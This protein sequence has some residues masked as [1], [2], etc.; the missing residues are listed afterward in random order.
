MKF[1]FN[2]K[3]WVLYT[4]LYLVSLIHAQAVILESPSYS[5]DGQFRA[6]FL[7]PSSSNMHYA[8]QATPLPYQ[9]PHWN[10]YDLQPRYHFG[11][12]LGLR[13][14]IHSCDTNV[15][16]NWIHF[17]SRTCG[18][19]KVPV[20][21]DMV[22]SFFA[23]GPDSSVFKKA[24]GSAVFSFDTANATFGQYIQFGERLQTNIFAGVSF[25]RIKECFG[26]TYASE[27][28]E[29]VRTIKNPITLTAGG[30]Q[31][32]CDFSYDITCGIYLSGHATASI[33]IGPATDCTSYSTTS[34]VLALND[35]PS[36]NNQSIAT[37]KR[38]LV[39]PGFEE[40]LGF[41]YSFDFCKNFTGRFEVGYEARVYLSALQAVNIG[42]EVTTPPVVPSTIGVYARTFQR[43]VSN[44]ALYG[45]YIAFDFTY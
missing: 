5:I 22:G 6:L 18:V 14:I 27:N 32:G 4:P 15:A 38:T 35:F 9:S 42:S 40:R 13:A 21:T 26:V 11:F 28:D 2:Y 16:L 45:P 30:P 20:N 12:D 37:C 39:V 29:T 31:I 43:E 17:K 1:Y 8:A 44:F 7:K 34:S 24:A 36:P 10:I 41:G 3:K 23:I 19:H 25:L 33:F